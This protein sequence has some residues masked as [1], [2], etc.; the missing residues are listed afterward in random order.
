MRERR[1]RREKNGA[2]NSVNLKFS[3]LH[4]FPSLWLYLQTHACIFALYVNIFYDYEHHTN[5]HIIMH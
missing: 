5:E 2:S 4:N 1:K 3:I